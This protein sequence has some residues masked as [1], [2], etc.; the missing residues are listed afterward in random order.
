MSQPVKALEEA[1]RKWKE[2][3]EKTREVA[4]KIGA[5]A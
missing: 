2:I 5:K 1:L 3:T 4:K